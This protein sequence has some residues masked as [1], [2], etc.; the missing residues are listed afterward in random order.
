M[1]TLYMDGFERGHDRIGN[2]MRPNDVHIIHKS[3]IAAIDSDFLMPVTGNYVLR[4]HHATNSPRFMIWAEDVFGD[5][6][7]EFY[8]RWRY[9][10]NEI[11]GGNL[12]TAGSHDGEPL[13]QFQLANYNGYPSGTSICS[14]APW[15]KYGKYQIRAYK[16]YIFEVWVTMNPGYCWTTG[17]GDFELRI[18]GVEAASAQNVAMSAGGNFFDQFTWDHGYAQEQLIDDIVFDSTAAFDMHTSDSAVHWFRPNANG[19][20][21]DWIPSQETNYQCV[22]VDGSIA[23]ADE[24]Y[25]VSDRVG[26][27]DSYPLAY[28]STNALTKIKTIQTEHRVEREGKSV[29]QNISPYLL[30]NG[31]EYTGIEVPQSR[32]FTGHIDP[33]RVMWDQN[34]D[35]LSDWTESDLLNLELGIEAD[36]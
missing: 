26:D 36:T 31:S 10:T 25:V 14:N 29:P 32:P 5:V 21:T 30:I 24:A 20:R 28:D 33:I 4:L 15:I 9:Q 27:K 19:V 2:I 3:E 13:G 6:V 12:F 11:Y 17:K 7:T 16:W 34:P 23:Q 22:N 18:D 1:S 8:C 35:T